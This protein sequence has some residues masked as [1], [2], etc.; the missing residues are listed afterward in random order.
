MKGMG[1][2]Y[3]FPGEPYLLDEAR[4]ISSPGLRGYDPLQ[5]NTG[6]AGPAVTAVSAASAR[7]VGAATRMYRVKEGAAAGWPGFFG[8]L[9]A[10]HPKF[11]DYARVALPNYVEDRQSFPAAGAILNG[12]GDAGSELMNGLGD[13]PNIQAIAPPDLSYLPQAAS[14][15]ITD[16]TPLQTTTANNNIANTLAAA[17]S[18]FLPLYQQKQL[19]DVQIARAKAGLPPLDTSRYIDANAGLNVGLNP[20]TQNTLLMVAGIAAA[21]FIGF[22]LLGSRR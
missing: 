2:Y 18:A 22:K 3:D 21:A 9:A 11:Y 4:K 1:A 17:A 5:V 20:G 19:L 13:D 7:A 10:T 6:L 14:E 8:W 12:L 16:S 15:G